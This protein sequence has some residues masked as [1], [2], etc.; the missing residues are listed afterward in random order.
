LRV[1]DAE[2]RAGLDRLASVNLNLLAPL[3]AL[4]EEC[5]VTRAAERV[6]L[7]QS[8]MSHALARMRRL[9]DDDLL[10]RQGSVATLTPRGQELVEPVRETLRSAARIVE[11]PEFDPAGDRRTVTVAM[12]TSTAF[13]LG[14]CLSHLLAERAPHTT[15]RIRTRDRRRFPGPEARDDEGGL[16]R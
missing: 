13:V 12:T 5:S 1:S 9:F 10:V 2:T 3:L 8:A 11:F 7:S 6:G 16:I 4:L 14:P 15:L